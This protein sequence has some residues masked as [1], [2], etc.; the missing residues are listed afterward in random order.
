MTRR[1]ELMLK[2]AY[3]DPSPAD[4]HRVLIDRLWPRGLNRDAAAID[5][6]LRGVA[7]SP[8]LRTWWGHDPARFDQFARRYRTELAAN[9]ALGELATIAREHG[10]VTLVTATRDP[11]VNHAVVLRDV[12]AEFLGD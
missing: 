12:L 6:W 3:D 10:R 7:P 4:G 5:T 11:K 1:P 2:R 9:P 8:G